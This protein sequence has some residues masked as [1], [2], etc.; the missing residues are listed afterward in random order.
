ML[1]GL[2]KVTST[3]RNKKKTI[4]GGQ[5]CLSNVK[6]S[7]HFKMQIGCKKKNTSQKEKGWKTGQ[8]CDVNY[9][10]Q[11][12]GLKKCLNSQQVAKEWIKSV[13]K[14]KKINRTNMSKLQDNTKSNPTGS[15]T[16]KIYSANMKPFDGKRVQTN[17]S[18][19]HLGKNNVSITLIAQQNSH[20]NLNSNNKRSMP[21]NIS[22][23][24]QQISGGKNKKLRNTEKDRVEN[25]GG[26]Q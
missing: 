25:N 14:Y 2:T 11:S 12:M 24:K 5:N 19:E 9:A 3:N 23:K 16:Q 10:N 15:T 20:M 18:K 17:Y 22:S 21:N 13:D 26:A 8:F 1:A 7:T 6:S 4:R